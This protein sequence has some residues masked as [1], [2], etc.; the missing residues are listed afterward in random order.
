M[1]KTKIDITVQSSERQ[2]YS[3]LQGYPQSAKHSTRAG[4]NDKL[5][6]MGGTATIGLSKAS[7]TT[8]NSSIA[9]EAKS[10]TFNSSIGNKHSSRNP[11]A[12]ADEKH[13]GNNTTQAKK[14]VQAVVAAVC[15]YYMAGLEKYLKHGSQDNEYFAKIYKEHFLQGFQAINFC[16]YLKAVDPTELAKKKVYLP[17]KECYKGIHF[18]S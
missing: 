2:S 13:H 9:Q 15:Q 12:I 10:F 1:S 6:T 17:K 7:C 16:K 4:L 11:A 3:N 14:E 18:V 5:L 8:T